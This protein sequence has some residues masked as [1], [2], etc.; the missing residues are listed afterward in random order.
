[1]E[2]KIL[3]VI[4]QIEAINSQPGPKRFPKPLKQEILSLYR[5]S[6]E[7]SKFAKRLGIGGSTIYY[8]LHS[9]VSAK[10]SSVEQIP[11]FKA[12]AVSSKVKESPKL[13]LSNGFSVENL[14][15]EFLFKVLTHAI[16]K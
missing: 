7:R 10:K 3:K 15:E 8:W 2:K 14:S 12:V 9:G 16:S 4:S 11:K 13:V 5:R 6:K 1:M